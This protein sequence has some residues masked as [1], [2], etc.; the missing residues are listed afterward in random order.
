MFRLNKKAQSTLEYAILIFVVVAALLSMQAY[1]RRGIKG[2]MRESSDQ[3]GEQYSPGITTS[4]YSTYRNTTTKE[5]FGVDDTGAVVK[6]Q[7]LRK[8]EKDDTRR[9]GSETVPKPE[10]ES[11]PE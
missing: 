11:F 7:T 2:K 8:F 5:Y 9:I 3:I 10:D 6:G 1:L 4:N